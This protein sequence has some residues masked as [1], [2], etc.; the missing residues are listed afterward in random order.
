MSRWMPCKRREFVQRFRELD[1]MI[2]EVEEIM[3]REITADEWNEL[4]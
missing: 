4:P 3:G 2:R 1:M